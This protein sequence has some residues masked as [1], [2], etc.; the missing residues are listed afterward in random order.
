MWFG[1]LVTMRWWDDLW[2]NESFAEYLGT[3]V[4]AEATRFDRGLDDLRDR[5]ARPGGTPP[6][7]AP[8]PTRSPRRRSPTPPRP[9]STST[10]SRTPRAPACCASSSPGS[11]TTRSWPGCNAHFAA[12]PLRQRHPGRPARQPRRRQRAGPAPTGPTLAAPAAG[13]HAA[14]RRSRVDAD[15]RYAAVAVVQTAPHEYPVL[16][17]HR[18][19]VGRYTADG[20]GRPDRGRPRPGRRRRPHRAARADRRAGRRPA[21]AQRRR[22]HLRQDPA[23]PG[24]GG[25]RAAG[26]ARPGRPVGPGAALGASRWTRRPTASGRSSALVALLRRR[27]P[28][29]PR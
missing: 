22:P 4:T 1:D 20:T 24:V 11:A 8:P 12:P 18:I 19:G 28:P 27:C 14:R 21:A 16:R 13:Q 29:R 26:A 15:G 17:P 9:C 6:T 5:A 7:S 2:L 23:R 10:A 3:R 25:R